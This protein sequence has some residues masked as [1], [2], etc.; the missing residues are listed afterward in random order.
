MP[1]LED[2]AAAHQARQR[3]TGSICMAVSYANVR[4]SARDVPK[5]RVVNDRLFVVDIELAGRAFQAGVR[6]GDEFVRIRVGHGIPHKPE[7]SAQLLEVLASDPLVMHQPIVSL[8]MG[9]AGKLPAEVRVA[10]IRNKAEDFP[11]NIHALMDGC[12]FEL[13]DY[14]ERQPKSLFIACKEPNAGSAGK[15]LTSDNRGAPWNLLE[16]DRKD[17]QRWLAQA[18]R[19]AAEA[20]R[21]K[22]WEQLEAER[23]VEGIGFV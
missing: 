5:L 23:D 3:V 14:A 20:K 21:R 16:V 10:S 9:F 6:P 4:Q 17:A 11:A 8:F 12:M 13:L 7:P 2:A 22:H 15:A 18:A 19:S 1:V